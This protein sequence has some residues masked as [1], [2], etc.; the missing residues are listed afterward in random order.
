MVGRLLGGFGGARAINR[1]FIADQFRREEKTAASA[2]FVTASAF[3]MSLGP[4]LAAV[5]GY[6]C[7]LGEGVEIEGVARRWWTV[8]TAPGWVMFVLWGVYLI[9]TLFYFE[10]PERK[11]KATKTN[12][13][14]EK[15]AEEM[16]PIA[17]SDISESGSGSGSGGSDK[18]TPSR[19]YIPIYIILA[20]Y[21]FL[22][23]TLE[24]LL[25]SAEPVTGFH[26]SWSSSQVGM[27]LAL[28]GL[29]LFPANL[30]V[31]HASQKGYEDRYLVL[32]FLVATTVGCIGMREYF[33]PLSVP[34][35]IV[36]GFTVFVS[37][38]ALE[39]V[40]M[41]LLS[42][43]IPKSWAVGTFNSG[44]LATEAGTAGR[45][46]GDMCIS[47]VAKSWGG[48]GL[49]LNHLFGVCAVVSV[50]MFGGV[51]RWYDLLDEGDDDDD[52]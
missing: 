47:W 44:L 26:F 36:F 51:W 19:S 6:W 22:K 17:H 3:G 30:L 33:M 25:S 43:K 13:N 21:F 16:L 42:K 38:N 32:F 41:G 9:A 27:Y 11:I 46:F 50:F 23:F 12:L 39:S 20:N 29:L 49:L 35:Y 24:S 1:R 52:E 8:E 7:P 14:V 2:A 45:A 37:T 28:L 10:E 48:F 4:G 18:P 15:T 31:A 5:L 40:S 34:Q